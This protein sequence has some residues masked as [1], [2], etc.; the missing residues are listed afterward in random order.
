MH[1]YTTVGPQQLG[2]KQRQRQRRANKKAAKLGGFA[3][4]F[5]VELMLDVEG[6]VD[7]HEDAV[8]DGGAV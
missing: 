8:V 2:R 4:K 3:G 5:S 7:L 1:L 6:E